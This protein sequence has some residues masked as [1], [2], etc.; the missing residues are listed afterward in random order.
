MFIILVFS[1]CW[2]SPEVVFG[3]DF[4]AVVPDCSYPMLARAEWENKLGD[5]SIF[6]VFTAA[7]AWR[8]QSAFI[9]GVYSRPEANTADQAII[10]V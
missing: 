9:L 5:V 7:Q 6:T 4:D 10:V 8:E 3:L 2:G 1:T